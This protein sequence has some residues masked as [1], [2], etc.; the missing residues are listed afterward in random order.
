MS[1]LALEMRSVSKTARSSRFQE[2]KED[3]ERRFAEWKNQRKEKAKATTLLLPNLIRGE[4]E[5][6]RRD[7]LLRIEIDPPYTFGA[8]YEE[9]RIVFD[10]SHMDSGVWFT[11][12]KSK[13]L[14]DGARAIARWALRQGFQVRTYKWKR[15]DERYL[16]LHRTCHEVDRDRSLV[17]PFSDQHRYDYTLYEGIVISWS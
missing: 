8:D 3:F 5:R 2:E 15:D 12:A 7:I 4:A 6:G 10:F 1:T 13:L 11:L 17:V 14:P 9:F 16:H